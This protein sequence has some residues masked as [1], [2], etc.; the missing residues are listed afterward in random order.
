M[1]KCELD[2]GGWYVGSWKTVPVDPRGSAA[3]EWD[4]KLEHEKLVPGYKLA[5]RVRAQN[6]QGWSPWTDKLY[7]KI[8]DPDDES[9]AESPA[10]D[11]GEPKVEQAGENLLRLTRGSSG[12]GVSIL[13][14]VLGAGTDE[15]NAIGRE[16]EVFDEAGGGWVAGVIT[17]LR[18]EDETVRVDFSPIK[19]EEMACLSMEVRGEKDLQPVWVTRDR[20][21]VL[22]F[23]REEPGVR[24]GQCPVCALPLAP[25]DLRSP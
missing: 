22:R 5:L 13:Q 4:V 12:A 7:L 2:W 17:Q 9:P 25:N 20:N 11:G 18:T 23:Y 10:E 1:T 24:E 21:D 6:S 19:I 3:G 16:V 15:K 8:G 14:R